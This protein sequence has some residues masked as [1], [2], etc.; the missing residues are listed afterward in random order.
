[1]TS[2]QGQRDPAQTVDRVGHAGDQCGSRP[3]APSSRWKADAESGT[4]TS[5]PKSPPSR[6]RVERR[7]EPRAR[8]DGRRVRVVLLPGGDRE[9]PGVDGDLVQRHQG[10]RVGGHLDGAGLGGAFVRRG[11]APGVRERSQ[12]VGDLERQSSGR[13][14]AS[15]VGLPPPGGSS[16]RAAAVNASARPPMWSSR[17]PTDRPVF[18]VGPSS[19]SSP[20]PRTSVARAVVVGPKSRVVM[21]VPTRLLTGIHRCRRPRWPASGGPPRPP[22]HAARPA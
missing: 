9:V 3:V 6:G 12:P 4:A 10:G 18:G 11:V 16:L 17:S 2:G 22:A 20:T 1:M 13:A 14:L 5:G 19:W 8:V 7:D 21:Q 15:A